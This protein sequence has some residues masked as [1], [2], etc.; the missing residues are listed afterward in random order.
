LPRSC[1]VYAEE[2]SVRRVV[3]ELITNAIKYTDKGSITIKV[4][5]DKK[6]VIDTGCGIEEDKQADIWGLFKRA[7]DSTKEGYGIELAVA[8]NLAEINNGRLF[9]K[10]ST[11]NKGSCFCF[12]LP[13][14]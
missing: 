3:D 10:Y 6:E 8:R 7:G 13:K 4:S 11:P 12:V 2:D 9:L 14:R 1:D 5:K